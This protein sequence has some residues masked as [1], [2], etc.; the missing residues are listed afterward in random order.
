MMQLAFCAD[1]NVKAL[2][3]LRRQQEKNK[4][5]KKGRDCVAHEDEMEFIYNCRKKEAYTKLVVYNMIL[6]YQE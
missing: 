6:I 5:T 1:L 4:G 2:Q 3:K